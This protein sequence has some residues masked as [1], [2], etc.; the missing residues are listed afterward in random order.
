[1]R[2]KAA[3]HITHKQLNQDPKLP[4]QHSLADELT[5]TELNAALNTNHVDG[6]YMNEYMKE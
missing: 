1:M 2:K 6:D 3:M 5:F 4:Q